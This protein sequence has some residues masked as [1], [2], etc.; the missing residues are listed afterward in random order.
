MTDQILRARI[1]PQELIPGTS[2]MSAATQADREREG[3]GAVSVSDKGRRRADA[4]R[5]ALTPRTGFA[6]F[7]S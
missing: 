6:T 4:E 3:G 5:P 2:S 7:P 1:P